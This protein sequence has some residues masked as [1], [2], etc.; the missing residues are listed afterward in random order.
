M[1]D[2]IKIKLSNYAML[3]YTYGTDEKL[4]SDVNFQ[5][6]SNTTKNI[7]IFPN[8]NIGASFS[9]NALDYTFI[10]LN[11]TD[12]VGHCDVDRT[13]ELH[14]LD[15]N[16]D[17]T[18]DLSIP[19]SYNVKYDTVKIHLLSGF[20]FTGIDGLG[21]RISGDEN[22]GGKSYLLSHI[23]TLEENT[24]TRSSTPFTIGNQVYDRYIEIKVP[25]LSYLNEQYYNLST[26]T[27]KQLATYLT[28]DGKGFKKESPIYV[29]F[30][31]FTD[32]EEVDDILTYRWSK[33]SE[34]SVP[35]IDDN[36]LITAYL[37]E[38]D[39]GDY[40]EYFARYDGAFIADYISELNSLGQ[41]YI[42]LNEI[43]VFES[44]A[45]LTRVQVQELSTLQNTD[46]DKPN[47]FRP[48]VSDNA[49]SFII[50]YTMRLINQTED[51]Q[52]LKQATLSCS[53]DLARKYGRKL[54]TVQVK[55]ASAPL[56]I[57]NRIANSPYALSFNK[58]ERAIE[59]IK[60]RTEVIRT[61]DSYNVAITAEN[62][63]IDLEESVESGVLK[64]SNFIFGNGNG[65]IYLSKFD[66]HIKLKFFN[67]N[68]KD[69]NEPLELTDI[70][71][72][73]ETQPHVMAMVFYGPNNTKNYIYSKQASIQGNAVSFHIPSYE[74][75]KIT[76]YSN[77]TFNIIYI[78]ALEE[79]ISLYE[80]IWSSL[81]EEFK[82]LRD[83]EYGEATQKRVSEMNKTYVQIQAQLDSI[84]TEIRNKPIE[85]IT[86]ITNVTNNNVSN[87][88][89]DN[90]VVNTTTSTTNNGATEIK[91]KDKKIDESNND[92]SKEKE[93]K[94][95][96]EKKRIIGDVYDSTKDKVDVKVVL[97]D[98]LTDGKSAILSDSKVTSVKT[99]L[100]RNLDPKELNLNEIPG[101][102]TNFGY[103]SPINSIT[104]TFLK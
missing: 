54:G 44:Y 23:Y 80:G 82:E 26:Y 66:N 7:N 28:S 70:V 18:S 49:Y 37:T 6:I 17:L 45:D 41:T 79:E 25:S 11:N 71:T 102:D 43:K 104:P 31:Q 30:F 60:V 32:G 5:K 1:A 101:K 76:S 89:N 8:D 88:T 33:L 47:L 78:N 52:V 103:T 73:S 85:Q 67:R 86:N 58:P 97:S 16:I 2:S 53:T 20:Y 38:S 61:V 72:Q 14:E 83:K 90:R 10:E 42:I 100:V 59:K 22:S 55:E 84:L 81:V 21:L 99:N 56:K 29:E 69:N 34:S 92:T 63:I 98:I 62:S 4:I 48:I 87:T 93:D 13:L 15:D 46:F 50:E 24:I 51:T 64:D 95:N 3:E 57:F 96:D 40:F 12:K 68:S 75:E 35:Q 94:G 9:K 27:N 19:S 77:R 91:S 36:S 65:V 74:S 39:E